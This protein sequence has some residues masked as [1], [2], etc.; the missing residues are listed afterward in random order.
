ME[1]VTA[2]VCLGFP[3]LT[4]DGPRGVRTRSKWLVFAVGM[5]DSRSEGQWCAY[6][7]QGRLRLRPPEG[8]QLTFLNSF[9][10]SAS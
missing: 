4:V 2:V 5:E 9:K 3:L 7:V 1:Y 8:S 10:V 6:C